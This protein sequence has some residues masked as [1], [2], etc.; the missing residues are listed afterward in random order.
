MKKIL[1]I[2]SLIICF[3]S[4]SLLAASYPTYG[5]SSENAQNQFYE[6][7]TE[8][9]D[10]TLLEATYTFN[11]GTSDDF[12]EIGTYG[13]DNPVFILSDSTELFAGDSIYVTTSGTTYELVDFSSPY[14]WIDEGG[15]ASLGSLEPLFTNAV[16]IEDNYFY[17]LSL[18]GIY[19]VWK[20]KRKNT[21]NKKEL[22]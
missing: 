21:I 9:Y 4:T 18:I 2:I 12:T 6:T 17:I 8:A 19:L 5:Y 16:P 14:F 7:E 10:Q 13:T 1:Y 3:S 22:A 15:D 20:L 11:S